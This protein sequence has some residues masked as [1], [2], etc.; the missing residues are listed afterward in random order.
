MAYLKK[1]SVRATL[2]EEGITPVTVLSTTVT[3]TD[4]QIK[5]SQ[6]SPILLVPATETL[7]YSG[8]PTQVPI[9]LAFSVSINPFAV[10]YTD[11]DSGA[12]YVIG[13]GS[14]WSID[15]LSASVS[16]LCQLQ[17]T[18]TPQLGI[19]NSFDYRVVDQIVPLHLSSG[20]IKDNALVFAVGNLGTPIGGG[21]S[22]NVMKVTVLYTILTL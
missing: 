10:S 8:L 1:E 21:S 20:S 2:I 4:E 17:G 13:I 11:L 3:L 19:A 7:D 15:G 14:D 16:A 6:T 18:A 9:P 12:K 22:S 5:A